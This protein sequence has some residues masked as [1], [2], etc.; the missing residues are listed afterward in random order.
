MRLGLFSPEARGYNCIF[1]HPKW[2][3]EQMEPG[4]SEEHSERMSS[5]KTDVPRGK[6]HLDI[7]N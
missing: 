6:S 3:T 5:N 7:R 1:Y 4:S 2:V